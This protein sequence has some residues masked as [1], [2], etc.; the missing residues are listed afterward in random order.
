MLSSNLS[1]VGAFPLTNTNYSTS[2]CAIS[3]LA[4]ST[5]PAHSQLS[6]TSHSIYNQPSNNPYGN[7][8]ANVRGNSYYQGSK[9]R[10]GEGT[11][12]YT[13]DKVGRFMLGIPG[14]YFSIQENWS[15]VP[16]LRTEEKTVSDETSGLLSALHYQNH[17]STYSNSATKPRNYYKYVTDDGWCYRTTSLTSRKV[18]I[19]RPSFVH[20]QQPHTHNL[21]T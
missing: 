8:I 1:R 20:S 11:E 10:N 5:M 19:I 15:I 16:E 17:L 7:I 14:K 6:Y 4:V 21:Y 9:P 12:G 13:E 2:N 3:N 18:S